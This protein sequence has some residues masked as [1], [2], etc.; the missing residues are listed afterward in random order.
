MFKFALVKCCIKDFNFQLSSYFFQILF[1]FHQFS[2]QAPSS[3]GVVPAGTDWCVF[4]DSLF[5]DMMAGREV[6]KA[7]RKRK[8]WCVNTMARR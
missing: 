2:N 5:T 3:A 6:A 1:V 7:L 4:I 8:F